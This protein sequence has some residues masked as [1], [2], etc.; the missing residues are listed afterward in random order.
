MKRELL[1]RVLASVRDDD[2]G[3]RG[4]VVFSHKRE[5]SDDGDWEHW[6]DMFQGDEE[7]DMTGLVPD[8]GALARLEYQSDLASDRRGRARE[9]LAE[10]KDQAG[11]VTL[12]KR[13]QRREIWGHAPRKGGF[14]S[15]A[16]R[17]A[18][19]KKGSVK[20]LRRALAS[21]PRAA[22]FV[23]G[24]PGMKGETARQIQLREAAVEAERKRLADLAE[25]G[26]LPLDETSMRAATMYPSVLKSEME[27]A[28][29]RWRGPTVTKR[30]VDV[31]TEAPSDIGVYAARAAE[32]VVK[33]VRKRAQTMSPEE[34]T[35]FA[36]EI[37]DKA[38][39]W[40]WV[41]SQAREAHV[42]PHDKRIL[43]IVR[44]AA[45]R[46]LLK[47]ARMAQSGEYAEL[48]KAALPARGA[49]PQKKASLL[50]DWYET[51]SGGEQLTGASSSRGGHVRQIACSI[52]SAVLG[53]WFA[54][55]ASL[56]E[57]RLTA[58][59]METAAEAMAALGPLL[60]LPTSMFASE[61]M[62]IPS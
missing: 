45:E 13:R 19:Q 46:I 14:L 6:D 51:L 56:A 10:R 22:D 1:A 4:S 50:S 12:E 25:A 40:N 16:T 17:A 44:V 42:E 35:R 43:G 8:A 52:L 20:A 38:V 21:T 39:T 32:K 53:D 55:A 29:R 26:A 28:L 36:R 59:H 60:G 31:G 57:E 2:E 11:A 61:L 3:M 37:G 7:Q 34:H 30:K 47:V 41:Q 49:C 27:R 23:P 62:T 15:R 5:M 54:F 9:R 33:D 58:K 48:E 24:A 18:R